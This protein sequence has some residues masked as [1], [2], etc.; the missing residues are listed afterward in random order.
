MIENNRLI[1]NLRILNGH[2][3]KTEKEKMLAGEPYNSRDAELVALYHQARKILKEFNLAESHQ[4]KKRDKCLQDLLEYK[5]KKVWIE[6]PFLCDYGKNISIGEN[7]FIN[8]NCVFLDNN[9]IIIGKNCLIAL[10]VQIY[11]ATH[12]IKVIDRIK[13][14]ETSKHYTHY[15]TSTKPVTIGD[16]VWLGGNVTILPGVNVGS[17]VT[18][19]AGSVV[20][21]NIPDNVLAA[22]NPCKIVRE[23]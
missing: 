5:G 16:N 23:L 1:N 6:A 3:L 13:Y 12:P 10:S 11:T 9:K 22:G 18:I 7:T 20:N 17:N 19:G 8:M 21:K 4:F 14:D 2:Y 15:V